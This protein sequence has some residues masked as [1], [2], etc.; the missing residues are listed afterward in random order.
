M[1]IYGK[2]RMKV[3]KPFSL[4]FRY[5]IAAAMLIIVLGGFT[6]LYRATP[7]SISGAQKGVIAFKRKAR[8]D[9]IDKDFDDIYFLDEEQLL[10]YVP[11]PYSKER[12]DYFVR[13]RAFEHEDNIESATF[14]WDNGHLELR[15]MQVGFNPLHRTLEQV[16]INSLKI[17]NYQINSESIPKIPLDGDWIIR[18]G[19]STEQ[20]LTA[21]E[22]ILAEEIGKNI[23]FEKRAV[24]REAIVVTGSFKYQRLAAAQ[25]DRWIL[26]F[27]GDFVDEDGG[28][29][30]ADSVH[31]FIEAIGNRVNVPVIDQTEPS[32]QV[33][34]PYLHYSSAYLSRIEDP[35][36]KAEKLIQLLDNI[37]RQTNL[38]FKAET[39]PIE[40]WFVTH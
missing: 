24:E 27:S 26:M 20:Q 4:S 23:R 3:N 30:T 17:H 25:D 31:D 33:K 39:L 16:L 29:G 40:K 19:I 13:E 6:V 34:I 22:D 15:C 7:W 18:K 5:I 12:M 36:D 32:G 8:L 2:S 37:S 9:Y 14:W 21:L 38:Q 10:K 1:K 11:P 35:N 28:G